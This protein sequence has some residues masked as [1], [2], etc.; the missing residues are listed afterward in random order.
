VALAL[1]R[2]VES[3]VAHIERHMMITVDA[4]QRAHFWESTG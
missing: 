3:A 1:D 2:N 4:L